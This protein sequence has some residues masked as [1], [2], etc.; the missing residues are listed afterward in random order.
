[1]RS[2][3]YKARVVLILLVAIIGF[4]RCSRN[5]QVTNEL[6]YL[7]HADT[8]KYV[9]IETCKQCHADIYE[10]YIE[11]GMGSSFHPA[12]LDYSAADFNEKTLKDSTLDM[13]YRPYWKNDSL[14]VDEYRMA[15]EDTIYK[16]TRFF[17]TKSFAQFNGLVYG[18]R[19]RYVPQV[20]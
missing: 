2:S 3:R 17:S 19:R 9:G 12:I 13:I 7:N 1:M 14:L 20:S 18:N 11:T 8:V 16:S 10:S 5:H 4:L 6:V 15:G